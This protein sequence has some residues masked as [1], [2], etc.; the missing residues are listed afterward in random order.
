MNISEDDIQRIML[1]I[2]NNSEF[3]F[4]YYSKMS[5]RRRI[6]K[7]LYDLDLNI[8]V[9]LKKI[10]TNH[11]FCKEIAKMVLVGN[12]DLFRDVGLWQVLKHK[13]INRFTGSNKINIWHAGC[14]TG[15][16]VYSMIIILNELELIDKVN[17]LATDINEDA[18]EHAK[19]GE[20]NYKYNSE[21]FKNFEE[22]VRKNPFY[23]NI[24][25]DVPYSR[26]FEINKIKKT[27]KIHEHL[28]KKPVWIKHDLVNWLNIYDEKFHIILCR[29]VLV[30]FNIVV[31]FD[32]IERFHQ[33]LFDN[34]ILVLGA[35]EEISSP[36]KNNFEK[37][38][39]FYVKKF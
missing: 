10:E 25:N 39:Y 35:D 5:F 34:A 30:Y 23:S 17:I 29:N 4:E 16:E 15:Q 20:Y 1:A 37:K 18:L 2:Q 22:V 38:D 28:R 36:L 33:N 24:Y 11:E 21:C 7:V 31:Q 9:L 19:A 32:V 12:T 13:V 26:F 3:N 14:S 8:N 27:I 6:A